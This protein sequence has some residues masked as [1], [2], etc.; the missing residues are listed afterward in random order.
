LSNKIKRVIN[1]LM[2][3][4]AIKHSLM[5]T[6]FV[7][8]MMLIIEY[9]NV[10]TKGEWSKLLEKSKFS[11]VIVAAFLGVLP[12]CLGTFT[13]VSLYSHRII[14]F[15]ALVTAMVATSGDSAFFMFSLIPE[16]AFK[17]NLYLFLLALAVGFLIN[18]FPEKNLLKKNKGVFPL[19]LDEPNC[20]SPN[21]SQI[22]KQLK[23]ISFPR[24]LLISALGLLIFF[25]FLDNHSL[26]WDWKKITFFILSLVALFIII[27]VSDHF[28]EEHFWEH[29]IKK[30]LL[31]IFLWTLGAL[32]TINWLEQY[33]SLAKWIE[34]N[35]LIVLLVAI[36]AG[37]IPEAG[38]QIIL[39]TLFAKGNLPFSVLLTNAI[40][41]D[42]HGSLPL[43]AESKKS[44]FIMKLI[45][46]LLGLGV[47][48]SGFCLGW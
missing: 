9:I 14:N 28:L 44:F 16:K 29:L 38:P 30:H 40:V 2:W 43:L 10:Q 31:K 42:G 1:T 37:I 47:G 26:P 3:I 48:L 11:Q 5:I 25:L 23:Q 4:E 27:T 46:I 22:I 24:A 34:N 21:K 20:V 19:H 12:G 15:A 33:F 39:I 8:I 45:N 32:L 18:L 36:L 7:L 13:I 17:I 41:Q 35:Q 6:S